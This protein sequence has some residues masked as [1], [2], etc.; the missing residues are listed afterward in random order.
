MS[1]PEMVSLGLLVLP[2]LLQS[3]AGTSTASPSGSTA[4]SGTPMRGWMTWERYTCETDCAT[5]PETCISEHLIRTMADAMEAEVSARWQPLPAVTVTQ[6]AVT[7][8]RC[9]PGLC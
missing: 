3:A 1:L 6:E 7:Q 8:T 2:V 5:F 4:A 9:C